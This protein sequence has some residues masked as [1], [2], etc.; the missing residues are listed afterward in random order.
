MWP[1]HL[2][3]KLMLTQINSKNGMAAPDRMNTHILPTTRCPTYSIIELAST[4]R[5]RAVLFMYLRACYKNT[6]PE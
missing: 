4:Y 5:V 1:W 2:H 3:L 6:A